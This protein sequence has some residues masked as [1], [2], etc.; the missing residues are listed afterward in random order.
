M[1]TK[2]ITTVGMALAFAP[3][4]LGFLLLTALR[5]RRRRALLISVVRMGVQLWLVGLYLTY[6]FK[7][8]HWAVNAGYVLL[9]LAAANVSLLRE[10][11]LRLTLFSRTFPALLVALGATLVYFTVLVFDPEP[12]YDAR[13]LIPVAGML[14]GNSMR[15]TIITLERF[16]A[17]IRRD[18]EGFASLVTMGATV[19]EAV[20]PYLRTAYSAGLGPVLAGMAT[21]GVVSLPGMMTGQILGG[22]SPMVAIK[23]QVAIMMAIFVATE[24]ATFLS[25]MFS[26]R[27]GF[28][29]YGFLRPEI[30]RA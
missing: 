9:M 3:L 21:M 4:L 19:R 6:L 10:S 17:S 15:R 30:F 16:Y 14:L 1:G 7:L 13:Y 12:L 2:D 8:N 11:G 5:I 22:S 29:D 24:L 23:Y 26:L 18:Q 25:V 27:R 28:D 20:Q